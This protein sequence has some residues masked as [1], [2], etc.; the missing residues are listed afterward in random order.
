M[1]Y[2]TRA[3]GWYKAGSQFNQFIHYLFMVL[4]PIAN[5]ALC[6]SIYITAAV[7]IERFLGVVYPI[8]SRTRR[9]NIWYYLVPVLLLAIGFN[10]PKALEIRVNVVEDEASNVIKEEIELSLTFPFS[11]GKKRDFCT[12]R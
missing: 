5:I 11:V 8:R 3:F 4:F 1:I 9:R 10:I 7:S 2:P 6:G 12:S